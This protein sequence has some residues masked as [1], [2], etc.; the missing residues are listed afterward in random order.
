MLARGIN[1]FRPI[2][3]AGR[4]NRNH[5]VAPHISHRELS[6]FKVYRPNTSTI[7]MLEAGIK[8]I[9][10]N[11]F[12]GADFKYRNSVRLFAMIDQAKNHMKIK[13]LFAK[14]E[15]M[16]PYHALKAARKPEVVKKFDRYF[17]QT[18]EIHQAG[19]PLLREHAHLQW[20]VFKLT[21]FSHREDIGLS[22]RLIR[23]PIFILQFTGLTFVR[24]A[25]RMVL[26]ASGMRG[27]V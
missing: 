25:N 19:G 24:I 6:G 11:S 26:G 8:R 16:A 9:N 7:K 22:Q 12:L 14:L 3:T 2:I 10:A 18:R 27:W 15:P 4:A 23:I 21:V 1:P 5:L 17:A 13:A 20:K